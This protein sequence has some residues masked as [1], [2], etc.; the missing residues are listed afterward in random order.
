MDFHLEQLG[1]WRAPA[2]SKTPGCESLKGD[3]H[4]PTCWGDE[5]YPHGGMPTLKPKGWSFYVSFPHISVGDASTLAHLRSLAIICTQILQP[6][7]KGHKKSVILCSQNSPPTK[8]GG[9]RCHHLMALP[10]FFLLNITLTD[11]KEM[12]CRYQKGRGWFFF[13][14]PEHKRKNVGT[15]TLAAIYLAITATTWLGLD[16]RKLQNWMLH[17]CVPN[18]VRLKRPNRKLGSNWKGLR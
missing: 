2:R 6:K 10:Q 1:T 7:K 9:N 16:L 12:A 3:S 18:V 13:S 11:Q 15:E 5:C 14:G 17:W 8:K 4:Q